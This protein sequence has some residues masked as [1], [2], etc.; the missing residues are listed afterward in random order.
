M[1]LSKYDI[2][3]GKGEKRYCLVIIF[4]LIQGQYKTNKGKYNN[5]RL[6]FQFDQYVYPNNTHLNQNKH[7]L[8]K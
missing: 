4:T 2:L 8:Y 5:V 6:Y 1:N 3:F 7:N